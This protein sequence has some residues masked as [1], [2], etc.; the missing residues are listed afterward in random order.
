MGPAR[1]RTGSEARCVTPQVSTGGR[2]AF[3]LSVFASPS[4]LSHLPRALF[5]HPYRTLAN[6]LRRPLASELR[7]GCRHCGLR[8]HSRRRRCVYRS[9]RLGLRLLLQLLL[10]LQELGARRRQSLL[11][12]R[13]L[14]R[15]RTCLHRRRR[16]W[17]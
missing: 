1:V 9:L 11:R 8:R 15:F 2:A 10:L 6:P 7:T 16:R 4:S 13:G 5:E 17:A 12:D 3:S 14:L